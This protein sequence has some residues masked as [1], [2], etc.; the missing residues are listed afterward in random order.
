M[1][2]HVVWDFDGTLYDTYP[3]ITEAF[4]RAVTEENIKIGIKELGEQLRVSIGNTQKRL[5]EQYG[6]NADFEKKYLTYRNQIEEKCIPPFPYAI[7]ICEAIR[8]SGKKNYL[9]THR[10]T[11]AMRHLE[12]SGLRECFADCIS[13]EDDFPK[14]PDPTALLSLAK[15]HNFSPA[16]C[17]MIGDRDI[18][19]LAGKNAGMAACFFDENKTTV[20]AADYNI[21]CLEQLYDILG[22][23]RRN[24]ES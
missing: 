18:D 9:Y 20:P 24:R 7:E 22:L 17:I 1:Y 5:N 13:I 4:Y 10:D 6:L 8:E 11:T 16:E 3:G 12:K 14:K 19:I 15:K 21:Y 2:K 23:S